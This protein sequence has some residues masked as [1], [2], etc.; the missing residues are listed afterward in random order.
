MA[1]PVVG[2]AFV[3]I[4]ALTRGVRDD[5]RKGF[6]QGVKD[7]QRDIDK[8][9]DRL[10]K[11]VSSR[12]GQTLGKEAGEQVGEQFFSHYTRL[13]SRSL[14]NVAE[15]RVREIDRA[16]VEALR[17]EKRRN[18]ERA[19]LQAQALR[20]RLKTIDDHHKE[21]LRIEKA[22]Q[23]AVT[24]A[25]QQGLKDRAAALDRAHAQALQ[26]NRRF[27]NLLTRVR[28][29][30]NKAR[31]R[32]LD[33][34][35]AEALKL[36]QRLDQVGDRIVLTGRRI[37]RAFG[38][39][40]ALEIRRLPILPF[41]LAA[42]APL[43]AGA[44]KVVAAFATEIVSLLAPIGPAL[45][46]SLAVAGQGVTAFAQGAG[47]LFAALKTEGEQLDVFNER[48]EDT[49][50]RFRDLG[51]DIQAVTL[52]P[53]LDNI[54]RATDSLLPR[55]SSEMVQTGRVLATTSSR[56]GDLSEDRIFTENFGTIL[57]SNNRVLESLSRAGVALAD[58][59]TTVLAAATP[60]TEQFADYV[61]RTAEGWAESLRLARATGELRDWFRRAG[62]TLEQLGRIG[63]NVRR[64]LSETFSISN[65]NAR[66]LWDGIEGLTSRW[67]E[68]TESVRGQSRIN[69]FFTQSR[70]I[71]TEVTRLF[72]DMFKLIGEGIVSNSDALISFIRTIRLRVLPAAGDMA[73]AFAGLG[74]A[75]ND[76]VVATADFFRILAESGAIGTFVTT[77]RNLFVAISDLLTLPVVGDIARWS[78]AFLAFG[79]ALNIVTLGAFTRALRPM[80]G[81]LGEVGAAI[82]LVGRQAV[83]AAGGGGIGALRSSFGLLGRALGGPF[84]LALAGVTIGL[85]LLL[86]AHL[87]A[88][89]A[90]SQ[91]EAQMLEF[92][93]T[94]DRTTGAL[95]TQSREWVANQIQ[96]RGFADEL[97]RL[98][99]STE[100]FTRAA[101][102]TAS[103]LVDVQQAI[104]TDQ[105]E[106]ANDLWDD[107]A[108]NIRN[109]STIVESAG[110]TQ[111]E[112]AD[113]VAA[114]GDELDQMLNRLGPTGRNP[115]LDNWRQSIREAGGS[116]S[117]LE[118]FIAEVN[119]RLD[120]EQERLREV[121][122]AAGVTTLEVQTL[123]D[124]IGVLGDEFSTADEK[125]RALDDALDVLAG[126]ER[127]VDETTRRL[128]ETFR[129]AEDAFIDTAAS[130]EA[131]KDVYLDL[132]SAIDDATGK[133]DQTT[134]VGAIVANTYDDLFDKASEAALAIAETGAGAD[135]VREPFDKMEAQFRELLETA[136]ATP[137]EIDA[138]VSS[139]KTL[140]TETIVD[141]ILNSDQFDDPVA[142]AQQTIEELDGTQAIAKLVGDDI[143]LANKIV[144]NRDDLGKIDS[145]I[146]T[147]T[148]NLDDEEAQQV[149][150]RIFDLLLTID[151]SVPTA[152]AKLDREALQRE[153]DRVN[154]DIRNLDNARPTPKT[155][156]DREVF[157]A[158]RRRI[159]EQM[160]N[161]D[162]RT[163]SPTVEVDDEA[164]TLIGRINRQLTVTGSRGVTPRVDL[165]GNA[166][167]RVD[168]LHRNLTG[169]PSFKSVTV[170]VS[171]RGSNL[172]GGRFSLFLAD[173]GVVAPGGRI[174]AAA[175][176]ML[177]RRQPMVAKG[178]S[179]ILWAEPQTHAE[180]YIPWA[181]SKRS[182][183][184]KIL[185]RTAQEF[186]MQ[187]N[188]MADG[189]IV[190]RAQMAIRPAQDGLVAGPTSV[191]TGG[192]AGVEIGSINVSSTD[193]RA[194]AREIVTEIGDQVY[195]NT[196]RMS[197]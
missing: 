48:L 65:R 94:L 52:T 37:G 45:A 5:I 169:L 151:E 159:I 27:E 185:S 43:A 139:L 92:A 134:E 155:Q 103:A 98:G 178:G 87:D 21:A 1:D 101:L 99:I 42:F 60:L 195:L 112:F 79:K 127:D 8:A 66:S 89:Q 80:L 118:Q 152:E 75:F 128:H 76:L 7:S 165:G 62:E 29:A 68:F 74:P 188:P 19:R 70:R 90:A 197:R 184:T 183:A 36:N 190:A 161:L 147:A 61:A 20:D 91:H 96:S 137:E 47:A 160:R 175:D 143:D 32:A 171:L 189:G 17:V 93:D 100:T 6:N 153:L 141:L 38:Q 124:A 9:T 40:I 170:D 54:E 123:A 157:E 164:S 129:D 104:D 196:G 182:K 18:L 105:L 85:G 64:A 59:L 109:F 81:R 115:A 180:S 110:I 34:A 46:A 154:E 173:G 130:A 11:R 57:S 86:K 84:G 107:G 111:D 108:D 22:N 97:D 15:G 121:A 106:R 191:S 140:P 2:T 138:I 13:I 145:F 31:Q 14:R 77:M 41:F 56:L 26:E 122:D 132:S 73:D 39:E 166:R 16:H 25:R 55:F 142:G 95:T 126:G 69:E 181:P 53:F 30:G 67:R 82:T 163:A 3:R 158:R 167:S 186:G 162:Q 28:T 176:G 149:A 125:A 179:N 102:G 187:V 78:L 174:K 72:A 49:K 35:H 194:A 150:L 172:T 144:Q 23:D 168:E 136:D 120:E 51:R 50:D 133:L 33:R 135:E 114:G 119:Q 131:G 193:P 113:A 117:E 116:H 44:V 24:R 12:L 148:A 83:I 156:L 63:E 88:R 177:A 146:A 10:G 192:S 4:R 71:T 58:A